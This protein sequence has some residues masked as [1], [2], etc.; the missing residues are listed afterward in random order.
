MA[1]HHRALQAS[2]AIQAESAERLQ[3]S[4]RQGISGS[5]VQAMFEVPKAPK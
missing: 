2:I 1:I 4:R 3:R 5:S